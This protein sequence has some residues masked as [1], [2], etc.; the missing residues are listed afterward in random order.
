MGRADRRHGETELRVGEDQF[1]RQY[2]GLQDFALAINVGQK[3][4]DRGDALDQP[5]FQ[6]TPFLGREYAR[7]DVE[8]D[9]AFFGVFIA[10]DG[11]GDAQFAKDCFGGLLLA[12][13]IGVI[14]SVQPVGNRAIG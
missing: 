12:G 9:D 1:G 4:V 8:G 7:D 10:I 2:A 6:P 3:G 5:F 14:G 11:K 13:Q